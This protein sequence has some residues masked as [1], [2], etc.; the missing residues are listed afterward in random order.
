M[1][2]A[3]N[4]LLRTARSSGSGKIATTC[5][6]TQAST[7]LSCFAVA[8]SNYAN[9]CQLN[10]TIITRLHSCCVG[11]IGS[12][13]INFYSPKLP[14]GVLS[15]PINHNFQPHALH[16]QLLVP[17]SLLHGIPIT[18][19]AQDLHH[20]Q[21]LQSHKTSP[22]PYGS[23]HPPPKKISILPH[24]AILVPHDKLVMKSY[25]HVRLAIVET[26]PQS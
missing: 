25:M 18:A 5:C 14:H 20:P 10:E 1:W 21:Y 13:P 12:F 22:G 15:T 7:I 19:T 11:P 24:I 4:F 6:V 17:K 23:P 16:D 3:R 9:F 26:L 8:P 2:C